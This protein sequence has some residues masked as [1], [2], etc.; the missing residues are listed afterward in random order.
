MTAHASAGRRG[1]PEKGCNPDS[2]CD[3]LGVDPDSRAK[4]LRSRSWATTVLKTV[5]AGDGRSREMLM[6]DRRTLTMWRATLD[7]RRFAEAERA[8]ISRDRG[9]RC[10]GFSRLSGWG[11][12]APP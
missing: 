3:S 8:A 12:S 10:F 1:S 5:V 4:N 2:L 7:E 9:A 6:I 11:R